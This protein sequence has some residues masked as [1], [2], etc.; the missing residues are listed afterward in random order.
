MELCRLESQRV[1]ALSEFVL[2]AAERVPEDKTHWSPN[3]QGKS[4]HQILEHLTGANHGFAA[5]IAGEGEAPPAEELQ[6]LKV[7]CERYDELLEAFRASSQALAQTIARVPTDQ[8]GQERPVPW[9]GTW[10][11]RRLITSP[12]AH[13]AYH[14]GQLC[15]LQTLWGDT[16]DHW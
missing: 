8:L 9:G 3:P 11:L 2:K 5:L 4:A 15:Y 12:S 16:Q 14:W 7:S 10:T 13:L 6:A 1:Q